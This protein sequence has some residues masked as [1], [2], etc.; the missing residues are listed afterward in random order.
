MLINRQG[1]I[2][3]HWHLLISW[4]QKTRWENSCCSCSTLNKLKGGYANNCNA[5][6]DVIHFIYITSLFTLLSLS[7]NSLSYCQLLSPF[8]NDPSDEA[9]KKL[10]IQSFALKFFQCP[11]T[12]PFRLEPWMAITHIQN[13]SVRDI[14][15]LPGPLKYVV[16]KTQRE[17]HVIT[18]AFNHH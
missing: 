5:D 18:I 4:S 13:F 1:I 15:A 6:N 16:M 9:S 11:D 3:L 14:A 12:N 8:T 7:K 17:L 10:W 2:N